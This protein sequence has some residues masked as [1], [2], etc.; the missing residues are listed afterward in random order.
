MCTEATDKM[1]KR[2]VQN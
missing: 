1:V 2:Y